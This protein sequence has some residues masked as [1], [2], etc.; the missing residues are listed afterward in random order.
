MPNI[1]VSLKSFCLKVIYMATKVLNTRNQLCDTTSILCNSTHKQQFY[2]LFPGPPGWA[3][4]RREPLDF[5]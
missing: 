3:G 4:A 2:G 5:M 1:Y